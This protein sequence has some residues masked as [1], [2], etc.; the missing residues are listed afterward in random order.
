MEEGMSLT[1]IK[2][3]SGTKILQRHIRVFQGVVLA[4]GW[5]KSEVDLDERRLVGGFGTKTF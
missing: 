5:V 4:N 2:N 3:R 1:K